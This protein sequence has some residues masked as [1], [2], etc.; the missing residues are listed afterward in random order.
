MDIRKL[1]LLG[2][3]KKAFSPLDLTPSLWL[4]A[5]SLI[6][7]DDGAT[8]PATADGNVIAV[9]K[10]KSGN[11]YDVSQTDNGMRPVLKL[12]A[13]GI[14][15]KPAI[16][17][18]GSNDRLTRSVA[19]WLS[20]DNTGT[21][22]IVYRL[23]AIGSYQYLLS[24]FDTGTAA[25]YGLGFYAAMTAANPYMA[26]YQCNNDTFDRLLGNTTIEV[27][28]NYLAVYRSDGSDYLFLVN[29]VNQTI[30]VGSGGNTGDWF[31]DTENRDN[32]TVGGGIY[33]AAGN[34]INGSIA[35]ILVYN[36]NLTG[37]DLANVE[38]YFAN[39]YGTPP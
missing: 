17:F 11:G 13:N 12:G 8:T 2:G 36:S 5:D 20:T 16:K 7:T 25:T 9:W 14:N 19:N 23:D 22:F 15:G 6:Y 35:E 26:V 10:D 31:S 3:A 28:T 33:N 38:N 37:E 27:A 21:I 18:D 34:F 24:T 4:S 32:F 39:K 30:T 1:L 29:G